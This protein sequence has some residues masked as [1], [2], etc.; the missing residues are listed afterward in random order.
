V[1]DA[2][3]DLLLAS[4]DRQRLNNYLYALAQHFAVKGVT[5]LF[6][7]ETIGVGHELDTRMSALADNIILL[8][9]E[10][11]KTQARRTLRVVKLRGTEHD[12]NVHELHISSHGC[13]VA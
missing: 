12:M 6:P 5:S 3:G 1:V 2:V 4:S 8:G 7:Y 13:R 11:D 10:L 9:V